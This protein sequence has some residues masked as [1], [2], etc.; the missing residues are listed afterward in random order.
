MADDTTTISTWKKLEL[1]IDSGDK[2]GAEAYLRKLPAGEVAHTISLLSDD[3]Q[4]RLFEAL[5]PDYAADVINHF[6]DEQA[7]DLIEDL[8][9]KQAAAI[10]DALDSDEQADILGEIEDDEAEAILDE[11]RPEEAEDV[12]ERLEYDSD[13]AGGLM[14]T[15]YFS[16]SA[17]T[18]VN[19]VISEL[20]TNQ[21]R[22]SKFMV[23]YVYVVGTDDTLQGVIRLH[24]VVL[25]P[26]DA[27]LS[28][29][30]RADPVRVA[31][32]T[33]LADLEDL[34]DHH[35]LNAIPVVDDNGALEGVIRRAHIEEAHAERSDKSLARFGGIIGGEELRTMPWYS[36]SARRL[37]F[38]V[39]NIFLMIASVSVI[40]IF[41]DIVLDR[42][43]AL[44]IF[45][46][47]V[48]GLSGCSGN[49]A[50]AVSI[51]ELTLGVTKPTDVVRVL[52]KE[53]HVG[54]VNG[55]V[56]AIIVFAIVAV[57]ANVAGWT[58]GYYLALIVA[59]AIPMTIVFSVALGGT[60]PL[61]LS[62]MNI[63]PAMASGPIITTLIDFFGFFSV[64]GIA[65]LAIDKLI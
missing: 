2:A 54:L 15:E 20:R 14:I 61:I 47:L 10:V 13:T 26:D 43:I 27:P 51:R 19:D 56:I 31:L 39:P 6:A 22:Y 16:Y 63:D 30:M 1:L 21:E 7:A 24:N 58:G 29:I 45:L 52:R 4:T 42:V 65:W 36:R 32:D 59:G 37:A 18:P 3:L 12:R 38:L 23:Q 55:I 33:K 64:L 34:F 44:A 50:V 11:M 35:D 5:P 62:R 17:D 49:Q 60:V 57:W 41:E 9:T 28:S 48:A 53:L 25:A 40:A 46:P 8:P